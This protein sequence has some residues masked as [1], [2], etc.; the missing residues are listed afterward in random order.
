MADKENNRLIYVEI[1][2]CDYFTDIDY[3]KIINKKYLPS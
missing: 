2:F 1:N 3:E